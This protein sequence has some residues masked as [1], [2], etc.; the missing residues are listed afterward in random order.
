MVAPTPRRAQVLQ[1]VLG[2]PLA[3]ARRAALAHLA[4]GRRRGAR[5]GDRRARGCRSSPVCGGGWRSAGWCSSARSG[6]WG[7]RRSVARTLLRGVRPGRYPRGGS[8]HLRL[9]FAEPGAAAAGAE[10]LSSAPWTAPY[11]RALGRDDRP[12][13]RPAR[14][15][16]GHRP[17]HARQ[18]VRGRARGR[19]ARALARRRRAATSA[20]CGS[21]QR[22]T[23]GTRSTLA[24]GTRVGAGRRGRAGLGGARLGAARRAL[25]GL[26]RAVRRAGAAALAAR[27]ARRAAA[28]WVARLRRDRRGARGAAASSRRRAGLAGRRRSALRGATTSAEAARR[29]AARPSPLGAVTL[30]VVL[31]VVTLVGGPAARARAARGL[32]PG[33]QP[34][35]LAGVGDASGSWTTPARRC[36]RSTRASR[37]RSG[38]GCSARDIG[39]D[40]EASTVLMLP[41]A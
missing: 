36:S 37:R 8:V 38:C 33:A 12:R 17:A 29:R 40:V 6:G 28:R 41:D 23:V 9:W 19:P 15:A 4:A 21:T 27:H 14:A 2:L 20:G 30:V 35:G 13:R 11:A 18:R 7:P 34:R 10:N 5:R 32:P 26:A 31:A 39:K 3:G 16:A 24:P 22:A 25:G 1:T